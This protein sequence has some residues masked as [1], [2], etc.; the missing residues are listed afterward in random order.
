MK[1]KTCSLEA[2]TRIGKLRRL[3][4]LSARL[5]RAGASCRNPEPRPLR[6]RIYKALMAPCYGTL[7]ALQLHL[8]DAKRRVDDVSGHLL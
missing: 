3:G 6:R 5:L 1:W 8:S 4:G 7:S 2:V